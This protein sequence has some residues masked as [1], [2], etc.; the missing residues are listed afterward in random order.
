MFWPSVNG[1]EKSATWD[2]LSSLSTKILYMSVTVEYSGS[3]FD[4]VAM[5]V[6]TAHVIVS[7]VSQ[8]SN[9]WEGSLAVGSLLICQSKVS[10]VNFP[11]FSSPHRY[12]FKTSLV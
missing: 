10:V 2:L 12:L 1:W 9:Q 5:L 11:M 6:D 3:W 4:I 8:M 7:D